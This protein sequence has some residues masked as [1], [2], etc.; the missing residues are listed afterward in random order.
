MRS[1]TAADWPLHQ[2]LSRVP[3]VVQW[4]L[5]QPDLSDGD[6]QQFASRSERLA[7]EGKVRRY[8]VSEQGEILGMVGISK[9]PSSED[10]LEV[11]YALLPTGRGRGAATTAVRTLTDWALNH[12]VARV[13]LSTIIG[14]APSEKVAI[15]AGFAVEGKQVR[16]QRGQDVEVLRWARYPD[17]FPTPAGLA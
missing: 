14:N 10:E 1:L 2:R 9:N 17:H 8:E 7:Q 12:G 3:D 4:T 15:R 6:A 16:A 11:F 5:Y 13:A